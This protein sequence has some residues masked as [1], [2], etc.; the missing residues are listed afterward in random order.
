MS[1]EKQKE[2][3]NENDN[4]QTKQKYPKDV[5]NIDDDPIYEEGES[6]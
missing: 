1:K 2:K 3:L 5:I 6:Q 4:L